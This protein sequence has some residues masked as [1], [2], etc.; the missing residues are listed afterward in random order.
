MEHQQWGDSY[1]TPKNTGDKGKQNYNT[2]LDGNVE[3]VTKAQQNKMY[4]GANHDARKY[5]K[6]MESEDT[7][8]ETVSHDIKIAI[9]KA[10]QAKGWNQKQL[11]EAISAK[12]D[13]IRDYENGKAIPDNALIAKIEKVTG[14]KLPRAPKGGKK[15]AN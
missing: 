9:Q 11:A 14:I 8:V 10:R 4:S 1:V 5:H 12:P 15:P 2:V 6:I 3:A 7:A 13:I